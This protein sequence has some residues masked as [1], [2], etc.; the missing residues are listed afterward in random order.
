MDFNSYALV[1]IGT[2]RVDTVPTMT[3]AGKNRVA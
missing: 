2:W 3:V 1:R